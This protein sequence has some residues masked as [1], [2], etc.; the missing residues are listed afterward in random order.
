MTTGLQKP[1]VR[2]QKQPVGECWFGESF[3]CF[4]VVSIAVLN[5]FCCISDV[6]FDFGSFLGSL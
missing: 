2:V 6:F 5:A 1:F 4:E 3:N